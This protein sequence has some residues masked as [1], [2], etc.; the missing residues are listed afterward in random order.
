MPEA[1]P[2]NAPR[3]PALG[4]L[5]GAGDAVCEL[6]LHGRSLAEHALDALIA[7]PGLEALVMGSRRG[8]A[9]LDADDLWRPRAGDA[10]VLHDAACPLLQ[11]ETIV[12]FLESIRSAEPGTA[13]V[14]VR[15]VTDTI[16]EVVDAAVVST[17][18]RAA[19]AALASPVVVGPEL[20]DPLSAALPRAGDLVDLGDVVEVLATLGTVVAVEVPSSARRVADREDVHLLECLYGLQH[21]LRER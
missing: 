1:G 4:L 2:H 17:V 9:G 20:L 15:P 12:H 7:V 8:P 10:L 19:L 18:D 6:H 21:T 14:G 5:A 13:L 3:G 11:A 16:K